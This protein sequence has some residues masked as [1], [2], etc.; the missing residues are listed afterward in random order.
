MNNKKIYIISSCLIA[1]AVAILLVFLFL[2]TGDSSPKD[3]INSHVEDFE[4][5]I[6][7]TKS[8][9]L[10]ISNKNAEISFEV[11]K[12]GIID[13]NENRIIGL[14]AGEVVVEVK[15]TY[16]EQSISDE[17]KVTVL[18]S[19]YILNLEL[20]YG[21]YVENEVLYMTQNV[22]QFDVIFLDRSGKEIVDCEISLSASN[23]STIE[24]CF[25]YYRL[26]ATDDC[27][28]TVEIEQYNFNKAFQVKKSFN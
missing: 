25:G 14:K 27:E 4:M 15:I 26:T 22:C 19:E 5:E 17:F 6:G 18:S 8:G 24:K 3:I 1:V 13:I 9:F 12:E 20:T 21:G 11:D 10:H 7:E 23:N 2:P 16:A 28:I